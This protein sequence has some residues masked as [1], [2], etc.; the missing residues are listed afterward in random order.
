VLS[1]DRVLFVSR[2]S[3]PVVGGIEN[4]VRDLSHAVAAGRPV[5]NVTLH[6]DEGPT[7]ILSDSLGL[8]SRPRTLRD[9]D[10]DIEQVSLGPLERAALSPLALQAVPG[11]RRYAFGRARFAYAALY[12]AVIGARIASYARDAAF[13]H[14][15]SD[16]LLANASVTG[17]R[18]AGV[19][20]AVTPFAHANRWGDDP[21]SLHAY[22][23]A[24]QLVAMTHAEAEIYENLGIDAGKIAVTGACSSGVGSPAGEEVERPAQS[25]GPIVLFIGTRRAGKGHELLCEAADLLA[26]THPEARIVFLGAGDPLPAHRMVVDAGRASDAERAAWLS[27]AALLCLPSSDETFG[28]VLL[29]AWSVGVPV[30]TSDIPPLAELVSASSGGWTVPREARALAER[31]GMCLDAPDELRRRGESGRTHWALRFTPEAI[32]EVHERLWARMLA[33]AL[34][35]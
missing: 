1:R 4:Y 12:D 19:P 11:V 8:A 22:G 10:V 21:L 31:L 35:G 13:V 23:R 5:K 28:V 27:R 25:D 15:F 9:G 17:A 24:D 30:V 2:R 6:L 32:A 18:R 33:S 34:R 26:A 7:R 14:C 20:V 29:E 3:W 16:G